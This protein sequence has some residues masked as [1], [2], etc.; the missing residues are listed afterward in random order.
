VRAMAKFER[1]ILSPGGTKT[2]HPVPPRRQRDGTRTDKLEGDATSPRRL[3]K[4]GRRNPSPPPAGRSPRHGHVPE[5]ALIEVKHD[6]HGGAT[7]EEISRMLDRPG[8][9]PL[10]LSP[11]ERHLV[12]VR[13]RELNR[14]VIPPLLRAMQSPSPDPRDRENY[15]RATNELDW[16]AEILQHSAT[17][18]G[19]AMASANAATVTGVAKGEGGQ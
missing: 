7:R 17:L 12:A 4:A 19:A 15:H 2:G 10:M 18:D 1:A 6:G 11:R 14:E 16:L 9:R 13:I 5:G 3:A 8:R